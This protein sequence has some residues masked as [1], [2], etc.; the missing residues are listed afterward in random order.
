MK[1]MIGI[2][3]VLAML[4]CGCTSTEAEQT[5][6]AAQPEQ[7]AVP[8]QTTEPVQ[9]TAPVQPTEETGPHAP[10]FTVY[11]EAGNAYKLS[12]FE[13][14]PVVLNFWA[15]WCGP[16]KNEMP[17]FQTAYESYGEDVHFLVV[18]LTDGQMETVET[19][20]SYI[21]GCGYTFPVY[22]D[23]SGEAA[24][25]YGIYSIPTTFFIH[26]DGTVEGYISGSI[27]L[28]TLEMAIGL[29]SK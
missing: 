22:C 12:D 2:L 27:D 7:T 18:N 21:A 26:A 3:L 19:A 20:Y 14:K 10:D 15:S 13:G 25:T 28:E 8:A 23:T 1:K 11:D 5:T 16:C 17:H 4:L 24:N 9:T 6:A 29:I